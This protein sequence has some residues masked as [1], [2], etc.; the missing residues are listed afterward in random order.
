MS[1]PSDV[2]YIPNISEKEDSKG[3]K[4]KLKMRDIFVIKGKGTRKGKETS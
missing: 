3:D 1:C 2:K 4:K